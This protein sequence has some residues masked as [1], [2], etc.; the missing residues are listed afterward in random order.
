MIDIHIHIS[1]STNVASTIAQLNALSPRSVRTERL[2]SAYSG[3]PSDDLNAAEL[4]GVYQSIDLVA[5]LAGNPEL[6][7]HLGYGPAVTATTTGYTWAVLGGYGGSKAAWI[8]DT[9]SARTNWIAAS[10]GG[11]NVHLTTGVHSRPPAGASNID[12]SNSS[13]NFDFWSAMV[14]K[15]NRYIYHVYNRWVTFWGKP[16]SKVRFEFW[17]EIQPGG[18]G[19]KGITAEDPIDPHAKNMINWIVPRLNLDPAGTGKAPLGTPT[20]LGGYDKLYHWGTT[21]N[22]LSEI[23]RMVAWW[24]AGNITCTSSFDF[25]AINHY[26]I[27]CTTGGTTVDWAS[28]AAFLKHSEERAIYTRSRLASSWMR[29]LPVHVHE[30]GLSLL[31]AGLTTKG[32][33]MSSYTRGQML[34]AEHQMLRSIF[35]RAHLY[36]LHDG[37]ATSTTSN[38]F[39]DNGGAMHSASIPFLRAAGYVSSTDPNGQAFSKATSSEVTTQ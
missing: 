6:L 34:L 24:Q 29:G 20:F 21:S 26:P 5:Q 2:L 28:P 4:A 23:D 16:W 10:Y 33:S 25:I 39:A 18:A 15:F 27:M 12:G 14:Y 13:G 32:R 1:G 30:H 19:G 31:T 8:A 7:L 17:N 9:G 35:T 36:T 3:M 37:L 11:T 38:G 22:E